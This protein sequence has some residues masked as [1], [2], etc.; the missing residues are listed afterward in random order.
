LHPPHDPHP[1]RHPA[2]DPDPTITR[3]TSNDHESDP[4]IKDHA[5]RAIRIQRSHD[6]D[7]T[8]TRSSSSTV[9]R[10]SPP[11]DSRRPGI[12]PPG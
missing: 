8:I 10:Y 12:V 3:S 11:G 4:T 2:A 6:S 9:G 7:P 1:A 5:I